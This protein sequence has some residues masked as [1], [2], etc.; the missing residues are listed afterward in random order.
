[1][2]CLLHLLD[3]CVFFC[4]FLMIRRPPKPTRTDT[5]VPYTT[6]FRSHDHQIE[7][8][9]D[10]LPRGTLEV[11]PS[12]FDRRSCARTE[13]SA[14][15]LRRDHQAR[16]DPRCRSENLPSELSRIL[17]E[18]LVRLR[19]QPQRRSE[20]NT[21]ELQSLLRISYDVLCFKNKK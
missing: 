14:L 6:L 21:P 5:L 16:R 11:A 3:I 8:S 15:Q 10:R 1:M 2:R 7:H 12:R 13:R 9:G 20:E 19:D 18:A 17:R 4:F